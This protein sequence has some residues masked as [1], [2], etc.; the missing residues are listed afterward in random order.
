MGKVGKFIVGG[1]LIIGGAI[2][3]IVSGGSL[4]QLG[5]AMAST[6][7]GVLMRPNISQDLGQ[8]QGMIL[9]TRQGTQWAIPVI[10]GTTRVGGVKVDVRP[11]PLVRCR[12]WVA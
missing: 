4:W 9:S 11:G 6:G 3:T 2:V 1:L 8:Q 10:Y 12:S 5:V 7:V